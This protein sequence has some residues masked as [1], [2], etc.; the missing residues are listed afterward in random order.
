MAIKFK[1]FQPTEYVMKITK[2]KISKQGAG[3]SF[4]YNTLTTSMLVLPTTALSTGFAF[5]DMM[6]A[7]FQTM[8]VQ[9]DIAY[10]ISDYTKAAKMVN[11]AYSENKLENAETQSQANAQMAKRIIN[12]LKVYTTK[13]I[14]GKKVTEAITASN[15]LAAMLDENLKNNEVIDNLGIQILSISILGIQA[16]PE[17]RKAL[18][19]ATREEILRQQDDAIYKRRN[20]A[21]EQE[22]IVKE[23]ELNTE[24]KVAEKEKEKKEK[25]METERLIMEK[26]AELNKEKKEKEIETERLVMEKRAELDK[27]KL[28]NNIRL[29]QK[30]VEFVDLQIAN[31]KKR[32]DA[33]AYDSQVLLNT[34]TGVD[35]EVLKALAITGMDSK[36]L[37]AKAFMDM[38]DRADRIG[39]LNIS[40]DL[41]NA[42]TAK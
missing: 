16:K 15:E 5:D 25:E 42:L 22:R 7:D 29:E 40:P 27:E 26:Q 37:I 39:S 28:E 9:G 10:T 19:A 30:N 2:G 31:E 33:R 32:S 21:I 24:I 18:E 1:K 17:T 3:L 35:I 11:F 6:T 13:F 20:A 8:N 34:F 23:N 4:F 38:G 12:L 41:L 36:A 14:S